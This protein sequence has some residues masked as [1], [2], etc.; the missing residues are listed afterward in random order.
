V[1]AARRVTPAAALSRP[2]QAS[3][4]PSRGTRRIGYGARTLGHDGRYRWSRWNTTA[5][6]QDQLLYA[7]GIGIGIDTSSPLQR[8][9]PHLTS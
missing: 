3:A 6:P 1:S 8:R 9:V 5:I 4:E 7:I 2:D